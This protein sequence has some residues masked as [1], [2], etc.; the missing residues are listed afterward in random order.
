[1]NAE[2]ETIPRP[3]P[4]VR[5]LILGLPVGLIVTTVIAM[6][7]YF[8]DEEQDRAR[9]SR[10]A[11]RQPVDRTELE[12]HVQML[13]G[14]IG[15]RHAGRPDRMRVAANYIESTLGP[16][17]FGY[18]TERRTVTVD[19]VEVTNI[20]LELTGTSSARWGEIVVVGAHV[21]AVAGSAGAAA[22]GSGVA[23]VM[24]LAQSFA[25][26]SHERTLRFVFFGNGAV[27]WAGT[28]SS[29]SVV[30]A[31]DCAKRGEQVVAMVE[32]GQLGVFPA[33]DLPAPLGAGEIVVSGDGAGGAL[34][35]DMVRWFQESSTLSCRKETAG[36]GVSDWKAFAGSGFAAVRI[37]SGRELAAGEKDGPE[38]V[39]Y[40]RLTQAA[41]AVEG[42]LRG[43]VNP[44]A[45]GAR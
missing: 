31:A 5:N 32:L 34:A 19:G 35:E 6:F 41:Q 15:E 28:A 29:G 14:T 21:D 38:T 43:V 42:Y 27:P 25:G 3:S 44:G 23:A 4:L 1:M 39:D 40:G 11:S 7:A 37:A 45:S 12:T 33:K 17:N 9:S 16:A 36:G 26:S 24:N 10:P 8:R 18:K 30:Y 20:V 13:G 22:N 2:A